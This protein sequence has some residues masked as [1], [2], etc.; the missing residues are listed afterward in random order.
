MTV[1]EAAALGW[2]FSF[3]RYISSDLALQVHGLLNIVR[4]T[5]LS[6]DRDRP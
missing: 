2:K 4:Q 1:A 3:R 6:Q 5:T